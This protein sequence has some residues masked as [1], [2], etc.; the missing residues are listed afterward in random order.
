MRKFQP[1]HHMARNGEL[2]QVTT[3]YPRFALDSLF[4]GFL[5]R[6]CAPL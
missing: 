2:R 5:R 1:R 3:K 4:R 6:T